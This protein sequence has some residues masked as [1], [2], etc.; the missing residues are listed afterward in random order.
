MSYT[1]QVNIAKLLIDGGA[2]V[3]HKGAKNETPLIATAGQGKQNKS[4]SLTYLEGGLGVQTP[5]EILRRTKFRNKNLAKLE[6]CQVSFPKKSA[7]F[8]RLN[9]YFDLFFQFHTVAFAIAHSEK[10]SITWVSRQ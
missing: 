10:V 7:R 3:N 4:I 6:T 2:N 9:I 8:A 1:D 5:T